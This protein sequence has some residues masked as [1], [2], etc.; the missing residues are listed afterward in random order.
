MKTVTEWF[1]HDI[2]TALKH[3]H[4]VMESDFELARQG[5]PFADRSNSHPKKADVKSDVSTPENGAERRSR[6]KK[7]LLFR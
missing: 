1:G 4:R 5:D 7:A 3:Y 6:E 2:T